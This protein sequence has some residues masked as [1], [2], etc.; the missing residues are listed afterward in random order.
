MAL[1]A[2][3]HSFSTFDRTRLRSLFIPRK[4]RNPLLRVALGL[5]GL[6]LLALLL[7]FG[8]VVGAGMIVVGLVYR[9][10]KQRGKP[11]AEPGAPDRRAL[12]GEYRVLGKT[13]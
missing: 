1:N 8:A 3:F 2:M 6:A 5:V 7:V 11:L 9:L 13:A 10:W 4:P 12:D